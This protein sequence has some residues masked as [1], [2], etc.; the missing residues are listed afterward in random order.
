ME[1]SISPRLVVVRPFNK[2][3][4]WLKW[5]VL[6]ALSSFAVMSLQACVEPHAASTH[7]MPLKANPSSTAGVLCGYAQEEFNSTPSVKATSKARWSCEGSRRKL[8]AN[9]IPDHPT[10][11]FPNPNNPGTISEQR[12]QVSMP[13]FPEVTPAITRKGGPRVM[14]G[15]V[16]NGIKIDPGT[17]G[18]CNDAGTHCPM[19]PSFGRWNIEAMGQS[20]FNFGT[21]SNHAHV[22]PGGTYHYH[23]IPEEFVAKLNK[24][25]AMTLIGWAADG[26]PVY[27][28]YGYSV[29]ADASSALQV[30]RGSYRL[31]ATPDANRPPTSLYPMGTFEQDREYVAGLGDLDECNGR[32]GVTPEFPQGIYHYYATDSYP[33]LQRCMKG[34]L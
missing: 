27:A 31:K 32:M 15:Y 19:G 29:A 9:G 17:A 26:F 3:V 1:N 21:D 7:P 13:L 8:T 30:M 12:I 11:V 33:Y 22:Q 20:S 2:A 6:A 25:M 23:G 34:K 5:C 16:L 24:G 28:R 10:G 18:T 14:T 4:V